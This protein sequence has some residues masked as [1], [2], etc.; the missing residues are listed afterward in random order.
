[1]D[2]P[3]LLLTEA[4]Q[5]ANYDVFELTERSS[6]EQSMNAILKVLERHLME[7]EAQ[8]AQLQIYEDDLRHRIKTFTRL[9]E[10]GLEK[11]PGGR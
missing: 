9:K 11:L 2:L 4:N 1:M 7:A 5:E 8:L 10:I 3:R 6:Y